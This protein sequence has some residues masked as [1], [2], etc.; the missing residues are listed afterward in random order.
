[1]SKLVGKSALPYAYVEDLMMYDRE[2]SLQILF[3]GDL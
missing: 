2:C 3:S 1:M